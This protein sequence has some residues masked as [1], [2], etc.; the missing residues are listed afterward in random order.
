[1]VTEKE[2]WMK[3]K[4][5]QLH[6]EDEGGCLILYKLNYLINKYFKSDLPKIFI[7]IKQIE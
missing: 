3:N 7:P 2:C 6:C 1:M 4:C 5:K